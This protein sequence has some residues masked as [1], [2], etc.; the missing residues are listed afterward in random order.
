MKQ[1][2]KTRF[3]SFL[4]AFAV[5]VGIFAVATPAM[6][7]EPDETAELLSIPV[8][9]VEEAVASGKYSNEAEAI[10]A[11]FSEQ[12]AERDKVRTE[13]LI[14]YWG[15]TT[16]KGTEYGAN[17]HKVYGYRARLSIAFRPASGNY[18][19][20]FKVNINTKDAFGDMGTFKYTMKYDPGSLDENHYY[21]YVGAWYTGTLNN[22]YK[23]LYQPTGYAESM[24]V[25]YHVWCDYI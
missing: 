18:N 17:Y 21:M 12:I 10:R 22:S 20:S 2:I 13:P 15:Y 5:M 4:T 1:K 6:A 14:D 16:I 7:A 11:L 23:V 9:D 8:T 3:F 24:E 25:T 19:Q